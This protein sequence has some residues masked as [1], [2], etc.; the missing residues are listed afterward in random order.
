MGL[1]GS[2][3]MDGS[4][5]EVFESLLSSPCGFP[6]QWM[7][8]PSLQPVPLALSKVSSVPLKLA[9]AKGHLRS[10]GRKTVPGVEGWAACLLCPLP[11]HQHTWEVGVGSQSGSLFPSAFRF[12]A[13]I[14]ASLSQLPWPLMEAY[15]GQ[16]CGSGPAPVK[17]PR[18]SVLLGGWCGLGR[19]GLHLPEVYKEVTAA[20]Q[21]PVFHATSVCA[22][23]AWNPEPLPRDTVTPRV[24]MGQARNHHRGGRRTETQPSGIWVLFCFLLMF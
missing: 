7:V 23:N 9:W 6:S 5:I 14:S 20:C 12:G 10:W 8:A 1:G 22:G 13:F 19:S 18:G 21:S 2:G 16:K 17:R 4:V 15:V 24:G 3:W 11:W